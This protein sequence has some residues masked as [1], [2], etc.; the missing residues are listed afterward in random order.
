M[1]KKTHLTCDWNIHPSPIS[2]EFC[3]TNN[4]YVSE[5]EKGSPESHIITKYQFY[6]CQSHSA[7]LKKPPQANQVPKDGNRR[8]C[9]KKAGAG[10]LYLN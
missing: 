6:T 2:A 4:L 7:I 10:L 3:E 9:N 5:T 8:L 1:L